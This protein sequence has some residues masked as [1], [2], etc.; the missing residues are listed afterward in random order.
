MLYV[1]PMDKQELF[2]KLN[3]EHNQSDDSLKRIIIG[4]SI[5]ETATAVFNDIMLFNTK[6]ALGQQSGMMSQQKVVEEYN[7]LKNKWR[8]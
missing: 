4:V 8:K 2:D 3:K 5:K 6:V 7:K 1:I